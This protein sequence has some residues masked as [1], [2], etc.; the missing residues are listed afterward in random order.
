M[1]IVDAIAAR[2][3]TEARRLMEADIQWN[4]ELYRRVVR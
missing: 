3:A 1:R 2:D 4:V